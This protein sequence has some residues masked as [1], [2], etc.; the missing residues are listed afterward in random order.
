MGELLSLLRQQIAHLSKQLTFQKAV[1]LSRL[2][3]D[4][5][6]AVST[7]PRYL[8]HKCVQSCNFR[9]LKNLSSFTWAQSS[10]PCI[11]SW[12]PTYYALLGQFLPSFHL[13][14]YLRADSSAHCKQL[15]LF[16]LLKGDWNGEEG[17]EL[18][19]E[20]ASI[21]NWH[22]GVRVRIS[23]PGI[24]KTDYSRRGWI[25]CVKRGATLISLSSFC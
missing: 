24:L 14:I 1:Y 18:R 23:N 13:S 2:A 25:K 16:S 6:L 12:L 15:Q 9:I 10:K 20:A 5:Y 7:N 11:F 21:R 4:T 8:C 17:A 19:S 22:A 3:M